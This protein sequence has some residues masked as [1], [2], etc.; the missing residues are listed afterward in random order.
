MSDI[1]NK[2][3]RRMRPH[4]KDGGVYTSKDFLDLGSRAAVDQALSR[5]VKA[6]R[7]RRIGR[8]L[9]DL[10]RMSGILKR[11]APIDIDAVMKA[12]VRRDNIRIMPD[13]L[14]AANRLGLTNAV[15]ARIDY[16][17]DG[18]S[19]TIEVG[20]WT[21]RLRHASPRVMCWTGKPAAPVVQAL[22]WLGPDA[23]KDDQVILTLKHRLPV[24]VKQNL[25]RNSRDLPHWMIKLV[26]RLLSD[27]VAAA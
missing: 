18:A 14:M 4:N 2:I 22:R 24:S 23:A 1:S 17:T 19:K 21:I 25:F 12:I 13:G 6:E 20:G 7:L 26:H 8:G 10:P 15:P 5:L 11:S 9:Y 16:V 27:E 3:I